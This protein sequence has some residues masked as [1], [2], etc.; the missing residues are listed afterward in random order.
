MAVPY[1]LSYPMDYSANQWQGFHQSGG[2]PI[3]NMGLYQAIIVQG[4]Q[5]AARDGLP[6][7]VWAK[8]EL[9]RP[10]DHHLSAA[11]TGVCQNLDTRESG[12]VELI[13]HSAVDVPN[14][15]SALDSL[16]WIGEHAI[17]CI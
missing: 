3:I 1:F 6:W 9:K 2:V 7:F 12:L 5:A 4:E 10:A 16:K 14:L 17:H 13:E 11:G 15:L 8:R